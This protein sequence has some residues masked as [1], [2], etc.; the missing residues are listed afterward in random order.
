MGHSTQAI[1]TLA[2]AA[3]SLLAV[4]LDI[5]IHEGVIFSNR[6]KR[7]LLDKLVS[8]VSGLGLAE[9]SY[10][11][12]DAYYASGK[13]IK[14][15]L[16]QG[17]DLVTR[18]RSDCV[19][20]HLAP[21]TKGKAR[22]G[23]P[24]L[25]G[26][27]VK[28]TNLF[29]SALKIQTLISPVYDE[30]N[31]RLRVR[32]IDLLWQPAGRLVRFV[33]V[34]HPVR[35]RL[36]LMCTDR[37]L[38]PVEIIRLY[39]LRFKIELGFKQAAHIVGSFGYH[40]WMADMRRIKRRGGNQY[41]HHE[42]KQYREAIRRKLNAYHVFLFMGVVTQGLM[43][44]LSACHTESVWLCFRSWLRTLRTG[45][46]PSEMVVKL[47]LRN[48]LPEFLLVGAQ[49]NPIAKFIGEHQTLGYS[50]NWKKAA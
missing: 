3:D 6:D 10:L 49:T 1:S 5:Q 21:K 9:P 33:L 32:S 29:R 30:R 37:S 27:K 11:V 47:A 40:F 35:G 14:G 36:V 44:Y 28:L 46:A 41:M 48:E 18:A 4:P 26:K 25:Y 31:V 38:E 13:I 12:A 23:R 8:Q 22:R 45:V 16:T 17:H 42:S 7:T 19:A 34:E 15:M 24:G 20:Y 39:G 43:H 50:N 2:R